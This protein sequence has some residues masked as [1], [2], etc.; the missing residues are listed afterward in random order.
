MS[1]IEVVGTRKDICSVLYDAYVKLTDFEKP[2]SIMYCVPSKVMF[3]LLTCS[4][5]L[6]DLQHIAHTC[7]A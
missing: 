5:Y 6:L 7:T 4:S 1:G 2:I 3:I